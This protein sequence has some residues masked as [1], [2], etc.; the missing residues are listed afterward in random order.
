[1]MENLTVKEIM[2][3]VPSGKDYR[4]TLAFYKDL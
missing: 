2:T 3:F 4:N 1:M